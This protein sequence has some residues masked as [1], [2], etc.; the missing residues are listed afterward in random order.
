LCDTWK[1]KALQHF[2]LFVHYGRFVIER[3]QKVCVYLFAF[4]LLH[5][6]CS[7]KFCGDDDKGEVSESPSV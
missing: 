3:E 6:I 2:P 7:A 1:E 5:T 4:S